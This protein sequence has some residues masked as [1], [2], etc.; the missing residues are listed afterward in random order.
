MMNAETLP[1]FNVEYA[2]T[3]DAAEQVS[4][5]DNLLNSLRFCKENGFPNEDVSI[6]EVTA[7]REWFAARVA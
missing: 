3:L 5:L 7:I 1:N 2:M 6:A 4:M